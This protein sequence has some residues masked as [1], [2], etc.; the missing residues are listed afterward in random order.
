M[1]KKILKFKGAAELSRK[2]QMTVNGG[3]K[4]R[5]GL[6]GEGVNVLGATG[7]PCSTDAQCKGPGNPVCFK[8]CCNTAV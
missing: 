4:D 7:Q 8:G 6:C 5:E 1:L 3:K 2:E